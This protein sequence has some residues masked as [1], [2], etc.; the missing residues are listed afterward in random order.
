MYTTHT[1]CSVHIVCML[2]DSKHFQCR[3]TIRG[4]I[5]YISINIQ[6]DDADDDAAT[7]IGIYKIHVGIA[8]RFAI[9]IQY[10]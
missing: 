8:E 3:Y 2:C 7:D 10:T 5:F 4:G 6:Y 9:H 1:H